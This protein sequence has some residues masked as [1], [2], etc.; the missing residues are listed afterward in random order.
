MKVNAKNLSVL[1]L[2][3]AACSRGDTPDR[4]KLVT[5]SAVATPAAPTTAKGPADYVGTKYSAPPTGITV[6]GGSLIPNT[7]YALSHVGTPGGDMI[8]FDSLASDGRIVR[9]VLPL[10]SLAKDERLFI[11]SCDVNGK[12]DP[13]MFAIV[14]N[15]GPRSKTTRV[16][17]AWR[18]DTKT[19]MFEMLPVAGITCEDP[20]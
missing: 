13:A 19:A 8:W 7:S 6:K 9:A 11:S 16:I 14:L 17:E 4:G 10:A 18:I 12:L 2:L 1:V 20:G 15:Q 3:C 5:D